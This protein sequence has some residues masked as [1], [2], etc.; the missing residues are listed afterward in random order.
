MTGDQAITRLQKKPNEPEAWRAL[1]TQM[2]EDLKTYVASLIHTFDSGIKELPRD[3]VHEAI[4]RF[5]ERWMQIR[6]Q[7]PN[8]RAA[9]LYLKASCRNLLIDKYRYDRAAQPLLDF[10]TLRFSHTPEDSIV[11][12]L[13][14]DEIITALGGDCGVLLRF[15][16]SDGLSLAEMADKDETLPSAFYS[17]WYRCLERAQELTDA[18]KPKTFNL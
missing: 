6:K 9:R 15:Y 14:V 18:K 11:R 7:I 4:T 17:R 12:N 13:L 5:W 1:Y 3:I 16:V 8:Y 2:Q 10:L